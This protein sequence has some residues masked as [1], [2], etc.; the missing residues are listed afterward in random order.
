MSHSQDFLMAIEKIRASIDGILKQKLNWFDKLKTIITV[1]VPEVEAVSQKG[2]NVSKLTGPEKKQ[3][4][5]EIIDDLWF[6]YLDSKYVPNFIER[7]LVGRVAS[8][9]ID[10]I[11]DKFNKMGIFKHA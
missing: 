9:L 7:M 6:R 2:E 1:V 8:K 3:L 4:A 11:V 5:L 10:I